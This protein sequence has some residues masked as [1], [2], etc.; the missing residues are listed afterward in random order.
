MKTYIADIIPRIQRFSKHLDDF[1]FIVGQSWV[2]MND[3]EMSKN[4]FIFERDNT[5]IVSS[6]GIALT[7]T[8]KLLNNNSLYINYSNQGYLL[9]HGFLDENILA[10][11]LD[12]ARGYAFWV[13]ENKYNSEINTID[14]VINFLSEKYSRPISNQGEGN[15]SLFD[16]SN[17]PRSIGDNK[18]YIVTS[19]T[20]KNRLFS[21]TTLYKLKYSNGFDGDIYF[22][23]GRGFYVIVGNGKYYFM[24][25]DD[26]ALFYF[27]KFI[28]R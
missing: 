10:L 3:L 5:L 23:S 19:T 27:K 2:S 25:M 8:W 9:K 21:K 4:V 11:K 16:T 17:E 1:T 13:N 12:G 28:A 7:G 15:T 22:K 6:N 14:D 20:R 26:A 18:S 24:N